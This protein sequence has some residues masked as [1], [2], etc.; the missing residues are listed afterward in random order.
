MTIR[1][2]EEL[3]AAVVS[4]RRRSRHPRRAVDSSWRF[5]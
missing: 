2:L 4:G 1:R 5:R 3:V